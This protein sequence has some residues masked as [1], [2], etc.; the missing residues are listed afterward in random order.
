MF[1]KQ[2]HTESLQ[3]IWRNCFSLLVYLFT[4]SEDSKAKRFQQAALSSVG[5]HGAADSKTRLSGARR[6]AS[7]STALG[8]P[9]FRFLCQHT[10]HKTSSARAI[11]RSF[12]RRQQ[13]SSPRP[14][15]KTV[16]LSLDTLRKK[17][18]P[19]DPRNRANKDWMLLS[20]CVNTWMISTMGLFI[21][22][23]LSLLS[24]SKSNNTHTRAR[25]D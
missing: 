23:S 21:I 5:K 4:S 17:K 6:K 9:F 13:L 10:Q 18:N 2:L 19:H 11:V 3:N 24:L 1:R 8:Y 20:N 16:D 22:L 12:L 7:L 14:A 25:A 15:T